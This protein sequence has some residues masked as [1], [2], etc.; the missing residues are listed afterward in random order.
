MPVGRLL[1]GLK[2]GYS[3]FVGQSDLHVQRGAKGSHACL[4]YAHEIHQPADE[5]AGC[6]VT[7]QM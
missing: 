1:E 4:K 7:P 3:F 6:R 5:N 2:V